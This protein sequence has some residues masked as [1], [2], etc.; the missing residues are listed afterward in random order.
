MLV[1]CI[2]IVIVVQIFQVAGMWLARRL[3]KR[4]R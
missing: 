1:A 4:N 3:D 2:I